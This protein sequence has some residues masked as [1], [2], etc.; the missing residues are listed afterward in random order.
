MPEKE[1]KVSIP[2]LVIAISL[3]LLLILFWLFTRNAKHISH[4]LDKKQSLEY[5][6]AVLA[7]LLGDVAATCPPSD[8]TSGGDITRE[9]CPQV[10]AL[11]DALEHVRLLEDKRAYVFVVDSKGNQI[12]NGGNP[13]IA[14]RSSGGARPGVN[15]FEYV[16]ADGN[17]AVEMLISRA[18]TGGGYVEYKWP[19]PVT[20]Q[21]M[22]KLAYVKP[23]PNTKWLLGSALYL[24]KNK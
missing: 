20:K 23:V 3:V 10:Y 16:D 14:H 18:S 6:V 17:K 13:H 22:K 12:V 1:L 4:T 15:T 7:S 19:D 21:P 2:G 9:N 5:S 24:H 11:L 8:T